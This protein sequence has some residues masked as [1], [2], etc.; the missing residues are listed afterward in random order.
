LFRAMSEFRGMVGSYNDDYVLGPL[1]G[2]KTAQLLSQQPPH[3]KQHWEEAIEDF[4]E[5]WVR[6]LDDLKEF[7]EKSN[8]DLRYE[9]YHEAISTYFERPKKFSP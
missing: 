5:R 6:F 1:K 2:L 7:L 8:N 3:S 9:P 4:R